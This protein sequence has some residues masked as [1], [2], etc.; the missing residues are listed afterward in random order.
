MKNFI[1]TKAVSGELVGDSIATFD[2]VPL[3]VPRGK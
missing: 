2:E 3:I 1:L